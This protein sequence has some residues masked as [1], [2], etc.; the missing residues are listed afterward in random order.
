MTASM[1]SS[2]DE[3]GRQQWFS[4][5]H[6][7]IVLA[8]GHESSAGAQEALEVLCRTYWYPLYAYVRRRGYAREDAQDLTQAFFTRLLETKAVGA[9][10][11]EKG[12]FRSFLLTSLNHFLINERERAIAAKRGGGQTLLP[13]DWET[14][15][16]RYQIEPPTDLKP[17]HTFDRQWA[18]TLM[19]R[20]MPRLRQEHVAAG[21]DR[22]FDGLKEFLQQ[23]IQEGGYEERAKELGLTPGAAAVAVHRLRQRYGELVRE[24]IA[25]TVSRPEEIE[26]EL[27]YLLSI[28]RE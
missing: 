13:L 8:A 28:L 2:E 14:A 20:A 10:R 22:L 25:H 18:L 7:T 24:E 16:G 4:A 9:A 12:K 15:E 11:P 5:T 1:A 6:W 19:E 26:D 3:A 21:K 23:P 27:R 17:E